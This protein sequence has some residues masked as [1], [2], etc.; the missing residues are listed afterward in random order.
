[1]TAHARSLQR[2]GRRRRATGIDA[3]LWLGLYLLAVTAPLFALL[4]GHAGEGY[5][6]ATDTGLAL[7]YAALAMF[8]VNF[9]LTARFRRA[10]APFGID[11]VYHFHRHLAVLATG[12]VLAH[13]LVLRATVPDLLGPL[14]PR[15]APVHMSAGRL[16]L[17]A[18]GTVVLLALLRKRLGTEY[19]RWRRLH[20]LL[21]AVGF[22]AA[23]WHLHGAGHL[24]GSVWQRALWVA[25][26]A[27][28]LALIVWV[29]VLRPARLLAQPWRVIEVRPEH[30][31]VW[32]LA[33]APPP[34]TR[35]RFAPGQFVWL[36]LGASPYAMRE[37]PFSIASSATRS[38]RI[39]LAIKALG[40]FTATIGKVAPGATAY[41]DGPYGAFSTD[42]APHAPGFVFVAGGI[43]IAPIASMLRTAADRGDSRPMLL[44]VG[45]RSAGRIPLREELDALRSRLDLT[46][47]HV[48]LEPP[49]GWT[50]E[51][52]FVTREVLA[53]HWPAD[54]ARR[55]CYVCGPT[56][57]TASVEASLA[58]LGVPAAQVH[59]EL[60]DWV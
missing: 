31:R 2:R 27:F 41:V 47:V 57:M 40:D 35:L 44:V 38:D 39:E 7:G 56:P 36:T 15:E 49:P 22:A 33:L 51:R 12:F 45:N 3:A 19:E 58:A 16:A 29:R 37:H 43:G 10:T 24:L 52:G 34:G 18:L 14:D 21:A 20:A 17:L 55:E 25:Y 26:G 53:R 23:L 46:V 13:W 50:G 60:F 48:L 1:M 8:G 6:F 54:G 32:T 42:R 9:A 59:A 28:W 5:G 30:D 4:P 11:I